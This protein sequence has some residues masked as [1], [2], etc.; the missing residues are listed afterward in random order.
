MNSLIL[1]F[2]VARDLLISKMTRKIQFLV[3]AAQWVNFAFSL[4]M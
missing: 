1:P 4:R 2:D 3:C